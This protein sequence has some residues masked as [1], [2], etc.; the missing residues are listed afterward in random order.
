MAAAAAPEPALEALHAKYADDSDEDDTCTAETPTPAVQLSG[1]QSVAGLIAAAATAAE[2]EQQQPGNSEL[3]G[4]QED[5]WY[6]EYEEEDDD[7]SDDEELYAALE[8]ADDNEG[9][10]LHGAAVSAKTVAAHVALHATLHTW[11]LCLSFCMSR[12]WLLSLCMLECAACCMLAQQERAGPA[13]VQQS[14]QQASKYITLRIL[15]RVSHRICQ[16]LLL[17]LLPGHMARGHASGAFQHLPSSGA[18]H[19]RP[20]AARQQQQQSGSSIGTKQALQPNQNNMQKLSSRIC[21][22]DDPLDSL[23]GHK[24]SAGVANTLKVSSAKAAA[25]RVRAGDKSD[26]ATVEQALDPRTRMVSSVM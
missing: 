16:L 25:A 8:W 12:R 26:R 4:G 24:L 3:Q 21:V 7:E 22:R 11:R 13:V 5:D 17:L 14:L 15:L 2:Q 6:D 20:N 9:V 19:Y 1:D 23:D 10:R 18:A